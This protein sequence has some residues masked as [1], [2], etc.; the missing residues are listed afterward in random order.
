MGRMIVILCATLAAATPL[1]GVRLR[2]PRTDIRSAIRNTPLVVARESLMS[3]RSRVVERRYAA[4]IPPLLTT[5][6]ALAF[7]ESQQIGRRP[8]LDGI[9]GD[10]RQQILN[11]TRE[12]ETQSDNAMSNID[13]WLA[14]VRDWGGTEAGWRSRAA[15]SVVRP[16]RGRTSTRR[17]LRGNPPSSAK[18][19]TAARFALTRSS[20]GGSLFSR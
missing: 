6:E 20:I 17:A 4:A 18:I 13:A 3:A 15:A 12:I 10:T 14:Q 5:A 19:S 2:T 1:I 7:F 16:A 8:G 11:Y 9:A